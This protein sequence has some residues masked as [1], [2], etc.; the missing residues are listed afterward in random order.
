MNMK[1][2]RA[3]EKNDA[4]LFFKTLRTPNQKTPSWNLSTPPQTTV[5]APNLPFATKPSGFRKE[6]L[7]AWRSLT[8]QTLSKIRRTTICQGRMSN[9]KTLLVIVGCL[10]TACGGNSSTPTDAATASSPAT[11]PRAAGNAQASILVTCQADCGQ[12]RQA[13]LAAG[14]QVSYQF[15]NVAALVATVPVAGASQLTQ[16]PGI[17]AIAKDVVIAKP[18]PNQ[19]WRVSPN[20]TVDSEKV[21][22]IQPRSKLGQDAAAVEAFNTLD[23]GVVQVHANG[24]RGRGIIVA[25][26]DSGTAN[27]ADIVPALANTVI[28]GESFVESADEPSATSTL[29]DPHG[30]WVGTVVAGH[31]AAILANTGKLASALKAYSPDQLTAVD[32]DSS[33]LAITGVAPE[34]K[35]YAL[36]IFGVNEAGAPSSRTLMA[37]DRVLTLKKNFASGKATT[38]SSGDGSENNPYVYDALDI[39]VVNMS[40]GGPALFSGHELED[41]LIAELDA[42]GVTVVVAAGNEGPAAMTV[43]NPG[44]S[45]DALSVGAASSAIHERI[46]RE[47]QL[48]QGMGALYRPADFWQVT[49]FSSRGPTADGRTRPDLLANGLAALVQGPDGKLALVSGT[50][51]AS[52]MVAGAAALLANSQPTASPAAVRNALLISADPNVVKNNPTANDQG[53]GFMNVAA[54]IVQLATT[55]TPAPVVAPPSPPENR[56]IPIAD[57]LAPAAGTVVDDDRFSGTVELAPGQVKQF[58]LVS[59]DDTSRF[60][61]SIEDVQPELPAT[62]QNALFGDDLFI[63]IVDAPT[64]YNEVRAEEFLSDEKDFVIDKPQT[65]LLRV[66]LVGD[67]TNIGKVSASIKVRRTAKSLPRAS[68]TGNLADGQTLS[69]PITINK[70]LR[71]ISFN[72]AWKHNW[73]FWPTHDLD[74][75]LVDPSGNMIVDAATLNSPETLTLPV[76]SKGNWTVLV[77]GYMLHEFQDAWSLRITDQEGEPVQFDD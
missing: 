63:A 7:Q 19:Q 27:N 12:A 2:R 29:N 43:G 49:D 65:G 38:P 39:R 23:A 8:I 17:A 64:S 28:G 56:P 20:A 47:L 73:A 35:L 5:T 75:I 34:A 45:P 32:A 61:V 59:N 44:N 69:I 4:P 70:T 37:M 71:N 53:K 46:L 11:T 68:F 66:A 55:P 21:L 26:I 31:G 18:Q 60:V 51:F 36:K 30:T 16:R 40:L 3:P 67:G 57:L 54:A 33:S 48:G 14:G 74:L 42:A 24:N 10:L 62:E 52:P 9:K 25:V 41:H 58:F 13:L 50:S 15:R 6:A 1:N 22:A 77:D 76:M 72:L